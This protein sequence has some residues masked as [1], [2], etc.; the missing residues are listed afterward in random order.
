MGDEDKQ[1]KPK[2]AAVMF[3]A[4]LNFE[5]TRKYGFDASAA[6]RVLKAATRVSRCA[7]SSFSSMS[8]FTSG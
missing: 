4:T 7:R 1:E 2:Q 6:T 8:A 5:N 3:G